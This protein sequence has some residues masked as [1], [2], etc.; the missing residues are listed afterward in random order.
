VRYRRHPRPG[1]DRPADGWK[2]LARPGAA[3]TAST[4]AE[5]R[6]PR[7]WEGRGGWSKAP[8]VASPDWRKWTVNSPAGA[9]ARSG[10]RPCGRRPVRRRWAEPGPPSLIGIGRA[11]G[12][13]R[14]RQFNCRN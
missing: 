14:P 12:M 7:S 5:A 11:D 3:A 8:V 13:A 4:L 2:T 1:A 10:A 9:S 6:A